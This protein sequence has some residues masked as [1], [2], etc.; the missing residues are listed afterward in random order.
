MK[1]QVFGGRHVF[2]IHV[3][4]P[5]KMIML[6]EISI[7]VFH[8]LRSQME[9]SLQES[10]MFSFPMGNFEAAAYKPRP[11]GMQP[12]YEVQNFVTFT[13]EGVV[14]SIVDHLAGEE[15]RSMAIPY[16][17]FDRLENPVEE[18]DLKW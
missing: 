13:P 9:G 5:D 14:I 2:M 11:V 17:V 16:D 3:P 6:F 12:T 15:S 1:I 10:R 18:M 8:N 4:R 7:D